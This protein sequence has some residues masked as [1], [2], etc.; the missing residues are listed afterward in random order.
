V[1]VPARAKEQ[2]RAANL[3]AEAKQRRQVTKPRQKIY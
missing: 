1:L 3:P 2:K